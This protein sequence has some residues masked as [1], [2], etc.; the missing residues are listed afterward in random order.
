MRVGATGLSW[1]MAGAVVI[2][3]VWLRRG[4]TRDPRVRGAA[5]PNLATWTCLG[6][7]ALYL[8][9]RDVPD[10]YLLGML[11]VV[12][13]MLAEQLPPQSAL[14]SAPVAGWVAAAIVG[15]VSVA[16]IQDGMARSRSFFTATGQLLQRGISPD[17]IDAGLAFGGIARFN[18]IYRGEA[19]RGPF[20]N[21]LAPGQW[22]ESVGSISPLTTTDNRAYRVSFDD[23]PGYQRIDAVPYESW[24]RSGEVLIFRR[25]SREA[26][27][28]PSA[29]F[30]TGL[31]TGD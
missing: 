29:R 16:G 9:T 13:L 21:L 23:E 15:C 17:A 6:T 5:P 7:A 4:A 18:P 10:R 8:A 28:R 26:A 1:L 12:L 30:D 25:G 3:S 31:L 22:D 14:T 27:Q 19:N 24:L 2:A 20:W 11:P